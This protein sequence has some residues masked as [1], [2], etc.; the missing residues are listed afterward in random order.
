[1]LKPLNKDGIDSFYVKDKGDNIFLISKRDI[2][3]FESPEIPDEKILD[4]I[5]K[6]AYHVVGVFFEEGLKWRLY[7]GQNR[8][9]ALMK[10][11]V[12]LSALDKGDVAFTKGDILEIELRTQQWKT[13][14]GLRTEHEVIRVLKQH[15][16]TLQIP[17]PFDLKEQII[18]FDGKE[19]KYIKK[20]LEDIE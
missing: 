17:L 1:M 5:A 8:I 3:Y 12:F 2:S 20:L 11:P 6:G 14:K 9:N 16:G 7:D 10:D 19:E 15:K 13:E 18:L 4:E